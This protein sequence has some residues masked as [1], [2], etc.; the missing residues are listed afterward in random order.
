MSAGEHIHE[1]TSPTGLFPAAFSERIRT[2][3]RKA[4]KNAEARNKIAIIGRR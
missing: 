1:D 2:A 3:R 4:S